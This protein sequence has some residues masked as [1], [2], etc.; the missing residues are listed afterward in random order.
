MQNCKVGSLHQGDSLTPSAGNSK[1]LFVP[2]ERESATGESAEVG[3]GWASVINHEYLHRGIHLTQGRGHRLLH[4]QWSI[5]GWNN[6]GQGAHCRQTLQEGGEGEG[7]GGESIVA[8]R[9][10]ALMQ[11]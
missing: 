8:N 4:Q 6:N 2:D 1:V 11:A 3:T 5:I 9:L 7:S 10:A